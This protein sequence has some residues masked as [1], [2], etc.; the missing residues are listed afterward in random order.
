MAGRAYVRR[1]PRGRRRILRSANGFSPGHRARHPRT[2]SGK[3]QRQLAATA[4]CT[5]MCVLLRARGR[6][7]GGRRK[8]ITQASGRAMACHARPALLLPFSVVAFES[9]NHIKDLRPVWFVANYATLY[10]RLVVRIEELTLSRKVR[11]SVAG[12]AAI[13]T[14]HT[15]KLTSLAVAAVSC[16]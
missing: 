2:F 8:H 7:D 5:H 14:C 15:P 9:Y 4:Q 11:K 10:L 6:P 3:R 1:R 12:E 16:T 13:Q